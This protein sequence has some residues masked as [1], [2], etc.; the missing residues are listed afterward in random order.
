MNS[1]NPTVFH[2]THWKAGSQWVAQILKTCA[3]KRFMP[4]KVVNPTA[5]N[6]RG[7]ASFRVTPIDPGKIYG[8]VYLAQSKFDHILYGFS[9]QKWREIT[10]FPLSALMN[11]WNFSILKKPIK[12]FFIIR[13]ARDTMLSFYFSTKKSHALQVDTMRERRD[14]LNSLSVEDGLL[15]LMES[16]NGMPAIAEIQQSWLNVPSDG[17]QFLMVRYEDLVANDQTLFEQIIDYCEI[18]ISKKQLQDVVSN[19]SFQNVSGRK[20]GEEDASAHLRKGI[21]GDW[22]NYFTPRVKEEFKRLYGDLLIKT[23]YE[24]DLQW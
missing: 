13:D 16:G 2:L 15:F 7:V 21:A 1:K 18:S 22:K 19:N 24:K 4:W 11:G 12:R 3:E 9:N 23:G 6:G 17:K 14:Q 8:T 20:P 10:K 5:N